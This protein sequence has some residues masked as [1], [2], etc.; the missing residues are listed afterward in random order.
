MRGSIRTLAGLLIAYIA[1]GSLDNATDAQ[2]YFILPIC[3]FGIVLMG[4]GVNAMK[5]LK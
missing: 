5:G 1:A 2:L 4:S 3:L